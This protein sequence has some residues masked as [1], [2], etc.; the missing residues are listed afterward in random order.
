MG[1]GEGSRGRGRGGSTG[2]IECEA[3]SLWREREL[4]TL[5][6][7]ALPLVPGE[8]RDSGLAPGAGR[9]RLIQGPVTVDT[10]QLTTHNR[11]NDF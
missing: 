7:R 8:V 4:Y 2:I 11:T 6:V 1:D 10:R 5:G 9:A 3:V